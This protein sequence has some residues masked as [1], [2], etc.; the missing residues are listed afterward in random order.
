MVSV[1]AKKNGISFVIVGDFANS[2]DMQR[3]N[4]VFDAI[5]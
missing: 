4:A 2:L 3:P 5:E 1:K